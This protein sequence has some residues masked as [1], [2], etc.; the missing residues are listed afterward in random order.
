M[1]IL[2]IKL[3]VPVDAQIPDK[4]S[5]EGSHSQGGV[6]F[7]PPHSGSGWP[8]SGKKYFE[9]KNPIKILFFQ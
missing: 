9:D 8:K 6:F 1:R 3:F 5:S 7:G 4:I 2:K